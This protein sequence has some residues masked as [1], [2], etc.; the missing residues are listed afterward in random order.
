MGVK[1]IARPLNQVKN[2]FVKWLKD[3]KA[4]NI[5]I[6]EG[7]QELDDGWDYYR[8]VSGFVEDILYTVYFEIWKGK[9]KIEYSDGTNRYDDL[10]IMQ[11]QDLINKP[12]TTPQV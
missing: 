10:D 4:T 7:G 8:C 6:F 9:L 11:F 2:E 5:D 3:N 12:P 1:K